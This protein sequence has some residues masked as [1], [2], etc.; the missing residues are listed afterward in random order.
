[1][2][3]ECLHQR[4]WQAL[5]C[6]GSLGMLVILAGLPRANA[7]VAQIQDP[8]S[9]RTFQYRAQLCVSGKHGKSFSVGLLQLV[10]LF[11][12]L[13]DFRCLSQSHRS[14]ASY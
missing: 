12:H 5:G 3:R 13:C 11:P 7:A 4:Y 9:R 10:D 6:G 1:M 8:W 14:P 2:Q